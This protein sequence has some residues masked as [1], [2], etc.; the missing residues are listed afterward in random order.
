M[1][2]LKTIIST[3]GTVATAAMVVRRVSRDYLP[4]EFQDYLHL[5]F[6]NFLNKFST[7][8][9]MVINE[10]DEF[11][12][13]ETFKGVELYISSKTSSQTRR[14]NVT[15]HPNKIKY[16]VAM[17]VKEELTD[18]FNG[19]KFY[20]NL[21]SKRI[22]CSSSEDGMQYQSFRSFELTFHQEHKDMVLNEYLPFISKHA[23][24]KKLDQKVV[25]QFTINPNS[26]YSR[27]CWMSV[28]LDHP[29]NF[30]TLA[31]DSDAKEK[32]MKDL[33]RFL[34][35]RELYRRVGKA[36][37]RGYLLYGPPGTGKTSLVAAMANYLKFDIYDLELTDVNSN[38]DLR[39]LLMETKN[40]SIL[41]VEDIDCSAELHDRVSVADAKPLVRKNQ[42]IGYQEEHKPRVSI[43]K[44]LHK[45]EKSY[46]EYILCM[47]FSMKN[48]FIN[49]RYKFY[50]IKLSS[51]T[52]D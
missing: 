40:R 20:W 51:M 26:S 49:H 4:P 8:L 12:N 6:H 31:M 22:P 1:P 52:F 16:E 33:D 38:S 9:T 30:D 10:F 41:V 24:K 17:E 47:I 39:S 2:S 46:T 23:E 3:I 45:F 7:Q 50:R 13:T 25:K 48:V 42:R 11:N 43:F 14:L 32:V 28:K 44:P 35:R 36:W 37:K 15:K 5:T 27:K 18:V 21:V 29:A 34:K 19:V